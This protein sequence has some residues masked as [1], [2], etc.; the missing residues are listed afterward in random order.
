MSSL[1]H[2]PR[3]IGEPED[4]L[5]LLDDFVTRSRVR[6]PIVHDARVAAICVGH[7]IE[8]LLI[9]DRDF[10]PIPELRGQHSG[11]PPTVLWRS[12]VALHATMRHIA[13][14]GVT[15]GVPSTTPFTFAG[16]RPPRVQR[17]GR[18]P[19]HRRLKAMRPIGMRWPLTVKCCYVSPRMG[20]V[21]LCSVSITWQKGNAGMRSLRR[22]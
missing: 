8:A 9:R 2:S 18:Y 5:E 15:I 11:H 14:A 19:C 22:S 16:E 4:F 1:G 20:I 13:S 6:G 17:G 10:L 7:G 21:S 3:L 12:P